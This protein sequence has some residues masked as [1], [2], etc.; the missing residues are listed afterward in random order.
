MSESS[1]DSNKPADS[2]DGG[3]CGIKSDDFHQPQSAPSPKSAPHDT[4]KTYND[5]ANKYDSYNSR[6]EHSK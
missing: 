3:S 5:S 2:K 6:G 1:Y 4:T